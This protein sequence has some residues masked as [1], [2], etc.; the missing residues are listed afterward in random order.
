LVRESECVAKGF[1]KRFG[2]S[3]VEASDGLDEFRDRHKS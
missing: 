3:S 1:V 2:L